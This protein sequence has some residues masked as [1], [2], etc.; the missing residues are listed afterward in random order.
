MDKRSLIVV[1]GAIGLLGSAYAL[2]KL[3]ECPK[4]QET[5]RDGLPIAPKDLDTPSNVAKRVKS[6]AARA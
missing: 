3:L 5:L 1:T 2:K 6:D 4:V